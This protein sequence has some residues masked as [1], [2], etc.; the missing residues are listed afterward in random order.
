MNGRVYDPELGRFLSAD[1]LVQ[2]PHNSQSYNRY[3]YVF[4]NP[5]SYT[6]PS[7]FACDNQNAGN[8][9]GACDDVD[10][11]EVTGYRNSCDATL[12]GAAAWNYA[13]DL[14]NWTNR[15]QDQMPLN[16][17]FGGFGFVVLAVANEGVSSGCGKS[18]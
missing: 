11:V 18:R 13:Q 16:S 1:P 9:G 12:C 17:F 5:L 3:S 2:S 8:S 10:E 4:N 15:Q 7:G 6:D 14:Q